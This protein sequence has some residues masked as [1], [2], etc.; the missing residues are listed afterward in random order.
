MINLVI[1]SGWIS[2]EQ[3]TEIHSHGLGIS[4]ELVVDVDN[5]MNLKMVVGK[6]DGG[7]RMEMY[8]VLQAVLSKPTFLWLI[9][10]LC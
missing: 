2:D 10:F 4:E 8:Q 1:G 9:N 7:G 6:H 5:G 3:G